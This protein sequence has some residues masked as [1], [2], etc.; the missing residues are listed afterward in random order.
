LQ[1]LDSPYLCLRELLALD[2]KAIAIQRTPVI[3]GEQELYT[4]QHVPKKLGGGRR[5][6]RILSNYQLENAWGNKF[7]KIITK[8]ECHN[9]SLFFN[10]FSYMGYLLFNTKHVK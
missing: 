6:I 2:P 7:K 3:E 10:N 4:V 8:D 9:D 1:Y 5:P